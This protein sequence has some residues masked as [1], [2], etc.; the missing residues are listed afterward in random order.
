MQRNG[1]YLV[2]RLPLLMC[3]LIQRSRSVFRGDV[4]VT[5]VYASSF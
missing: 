2:L 3:S 1:L 5:L 4:A